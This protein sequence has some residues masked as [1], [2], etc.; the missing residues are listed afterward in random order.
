MDNH[1][2]RIER[3]L[4]SIVP[5]EHESDSHRQ[6][7]R[8]Q[9][10]TE[11]GRRQTMS[12]TGR[13]WKVAAVIAA[14]VCTGAAATVVGVKIRHYYFEGRGTDGSYHFTTEPQMVYQKTYQDANGVQRGYAVGGTSTTTI[15]S[16]D[17]N[18]TI[19]VEQTRRDLEEIDRLR[20]QDIRKLIGVVDTE[21]NGRF[22]HRTFCYEYTLADGRTK[23]IGEGGP[24]TDGVRSPAQIE[25]D[26]QEIDQLRQQNRREL[27]HVDD[28]QFRGELQ[29]TCMYSYLLAD[30]REQT[31]GE[32]DPQAPWPTNPLGKEQI[33]E[34]WRLRRF[35]QGTFVGRE[36][37][38]VH[39]QPFTFETYIFTLADGTVVTHSTGEPKGLKRDLTTKDWEELR[40]LREANKGEDLATEEKTVLDRVFSF[41]RQR[42]VL[43]DG[44]E[45]IWSS[46]VPKDNP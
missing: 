46:G 30:G 27:V 33:G 26:Y 8:R 13:A 4:Q 22:Y 19:D 17:P 41:K 10:L 42:F 2:E 23:T 38:D 14:L 9:V 43:S 15:S 31:V 36:D 40:G 45:V 24:K 16:S 3:Y 25:K 34:V 44:T 35:K 20:Q 28:M 18:Q 7:L 32:S 12:V 6:Q 11:T 37:R 21:V 29:R 5:P 1:I 39:G